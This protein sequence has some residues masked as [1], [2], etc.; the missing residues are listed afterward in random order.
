MLT[1]YT[2]A[3]RRQSSRIHLQIPLFLRGVD[4]A[5][6]EFVELAK[7]LDISATGACIISRRPLHTGQILRITIPVA[8]EGSSGLIPAETPPI[9]ARVLRVGDVAEM[10]LLGI[11]FLK[12]LD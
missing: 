6:V 10:R 5:G 3:E 11:E 8:S 9:Q 4:E 7:T 2:E 1:R 12:P